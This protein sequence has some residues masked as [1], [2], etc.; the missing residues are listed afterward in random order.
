MRIN[1]YGEEI[2][3]KVELIKKAVDQRLFVGVRIY[4]ESSPRLH[5]SDNDNDET[6]ITFWAPWT[7]KNGNDVE[8]I[9]RVLENAAHLIRTADPRTSDMVG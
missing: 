4:L 1:V 9:A 7:K 2:R 5:H 3:D 6:G 8:I